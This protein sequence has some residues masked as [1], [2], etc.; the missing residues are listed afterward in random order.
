MHSHPG[1]V[2][3]LKDKVVFEAAVRDFM[4]LAVRAK[5]KILRCEYVFLGRCHLFQ[6][7]KQI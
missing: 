7:S 2:C 5:Y 4:K 6:L 1:I 3:N